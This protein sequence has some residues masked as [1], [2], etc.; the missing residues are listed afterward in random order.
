MMGLDFESNGLATRGNTRILTAALVARYPDNE[1]V[2]PPQIVINPLDHGVGPEGVGA[3][4]IHGLTEAFVREHGRQPAEAVEHIRDV[5]LRSCEDGVPIVGMNLVYD[6]TLL[7]TECRRYRMKTLTER[8]L[9][10]IGRDVGPVIDVLVI[11]REMRDVLDW[12]TGKPHRGGRRLGELAAH[13]RVALPNAHNAVADTAASM[14]IAWKLGRTYSH[15]LDMPVSELHQKQRGWHAKWAA[16]AP[17]HQ[18]IPPHWPVLPWPE[19]LVLPEPVTVAPALP[20]ADATPDE[21]AAVA[22]IATKFDLQKVAD[23]S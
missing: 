13:Y 3:T 11:D 19:G 2:L 15:R 7:D 18:D 14:R 9:H 21:A 10:S 17:A 4:K 8:C 5:L 23:L 1:F 6:L 12:R 16:A 22:A 20:W